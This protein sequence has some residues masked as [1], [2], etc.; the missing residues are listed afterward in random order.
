MNPIGQLDRVNCCWPSPAHSFFVPGPAGFTTI[1]FFLHRWM[2]L[3]SKLLLTL[4]STVILGSES[5]ETHDHILLSD[6]SGSLQATQILVGQLYPVPV[7]TAWGRVGRTS[8]FMLLVDRVIPCLSSPL[9][10]FLVPGTAGLMLVFV[11]LKILG[12]F[13]LLRCLF[14]L[15]PTFNM[16]AFS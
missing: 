6:R 7:T 10:S 4:D 8:G 3:T 13:R 15:L 2:S 11:S 9:L 5:H 16:A 14:L 12:V 1:F